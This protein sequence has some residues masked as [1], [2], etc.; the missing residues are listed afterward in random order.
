[1]RVRGKHPRAKGV[2]E[3]GFGG[4]NVWIRR[5]S[6][7]WFQRYKFVKFETVLLRTKSTVQ[8][9]Y[10]FVSFFT[11]LLN[12]TDWHERSRLPWITQSSTWRFTG[13]SENRSSGVVDL[14]QVLVHFISENDG[15][16]SAL[17]IGSYWCWATRRVA[18]TTFDLVP[19][20]G[21]R[22][23]DTSQ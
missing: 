18:Y 7:F 2:E 12:Q 19:F 14:E 20:L 16:D 1:M 22:I 3:G 4:Y 23:G 17:V 11:R 6:I 21:E 5:F 10:I 13:R 15:S 8:Q 9:R